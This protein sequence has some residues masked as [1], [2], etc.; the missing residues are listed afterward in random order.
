VQENAGSE[1]GRGRKR[2][3]LAH[4]EEKMWTGFKPIEDLLGG[5]VVLVFIS[6]VATV[7]NPKIKPICLSDSPIRLKAEDY[8]RKIWGTC[9][10]VR[11]PGCWG[12]KSSG[13]LETKE[14]RK[15]AIEFRG[16]GCGIRTKF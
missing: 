8:T 4:R 5:I 7:I 11:P 16:A 10:L 2:W 14:P 15:F 6:R 12:T 9:L 3:R 13:L 1:I